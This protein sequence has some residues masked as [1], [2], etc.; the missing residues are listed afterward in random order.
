MF[1]KQK[2]YMEIYK[3]VGQIGALAHLHDFTWS[4]FDTTGSSTNFF[5]WHTASNSGL[6]TRRGSC[7]C[8]QH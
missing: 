5:S 2:I 1:L 7:F 8:E 3:N 6:G 4:W